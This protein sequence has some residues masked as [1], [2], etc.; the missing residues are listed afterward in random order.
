MI[1]TTTP[2][3]P[4]NYSPRR[5]LRVDKN[6]TKQKTNE[7]ALQRYMIFQ[8]IYWP[9]IEATTKCSK[10][11]PSNVFY[12]PQGCVGS[13]KQNSENEN[14]ILSDLFQSDGTFQS[15][16]YG[17]KRVAENRFKKIRVKNGPFCHLLTTRALLMII[18][19]SLENILN[20]K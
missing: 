15:L 12:R 14:L 17:V 7:W 16:W 11:R 18:S 19:Q 5:S 1:S 4:R 20:K 10:H 3:P 13:E 6:K 2:P 8:A 9:L